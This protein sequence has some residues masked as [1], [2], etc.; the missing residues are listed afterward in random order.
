MVSLM[1]GGAAKE[2]GVG[3]TERV[4]VYVTRVCPYCVRA[5]SL[6]ERRGIGYATIDVSTDHETRRWLVEA[7]GQRTVPQIFIDGE[8][9]GGF[10]ELAELDRAG[11]LDKKLGR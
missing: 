4:I 2:Q 5:K 8:S 9:I 11:E 6:L 7:T 10:E 3:K 1:S